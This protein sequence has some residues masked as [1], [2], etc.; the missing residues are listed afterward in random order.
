[1][2]R[3]YVTLA[4]LAAL[5]AAC[6]RPSTPAKEYHLTGQILA[7]KPERQEVLLKHDD[8]KGF[9]PA[10]T[11]PYKVKDDALLTGKQPGDLIQAT[12]VVGEVDAHL[13]TLTKTGHAPLETPPPVSDAPPILDP[14]QQVPDALLVNQDGVPM[15]FSSL[16]GHRVALTF[17]YTRCPLP[18]FCPL[19]NRNFAAVQ[20]ALAK[21]ATMSDVRL[22]TI[23]VDPA[24]DTPSVLKEHAAL[25]KADPHRWVFATGEPK[26]II[27]FA[28]AFGIDVEQSPESKDQLIHNLR[29]AIVDA[30]GRLVNAQS[31][32][33]WTPAELVGDLKAT[34]APRH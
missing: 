27:R 22:L 16:R 9:M 11:M 28:A 21:D 4:I 19:M 30:D 14:G 17:I 20:S 15:P 6:S 34:P 24:Y 7:I 31:G 12:L 29:T 13:S 8:I 25:Y 10:M 18:D 23:T 26:E 32:N 33:T 2:R 1:M 5:A 3:A